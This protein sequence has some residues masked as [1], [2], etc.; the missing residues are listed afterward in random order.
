MAQ[1][2]VPENLDNFSVEDFLNSAIRLRLSDIL[3]SM[4]ENLDSFDDEQKEN[5]T[6]K[7]RTVAGQEVRRVC[8]MGTVVTIQN[9]ESDVVTYI[10]DGTERALV[11]IPKNSSEVLSNLTT[12]K[13]V[14]VIG[15]VSIQQDPLTSENELVID[16]EIIRV[17]DSD[18]EEFL[19]RFDAVRSRLLIKHLNEIKRMQQKAEKRMEDQVILDTDGNPLSRE[20]V[21]DIIRRVIQRLDVNQKGVSFEEIMEALQQEGYQITEEML[22]ELILDLMDDGELFEPRAGYYQLVY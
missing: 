16:T 20:D 5:S 15:R 7:I 21:L 6:S 13:T 19:H 1:P 8:V 22:D 11:R 12:W 9:F 3:E 18:M 17:A 4:P 2:L 10:D 14:R